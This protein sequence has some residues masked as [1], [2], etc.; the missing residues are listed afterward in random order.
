MRGQLFIFLVNFNLVSKFCVIPNYF[1]LPY[2]FYQGCC[3]LQHSKLR[4]TQYPINSSFLFHSFNCAGTSVHVFVELY[5]GLNQRTVEKKKKNIFTWINS[6]TCFISLLPF[7]KYCASTTK[8]TTC[9]NILNTM[10]CSVY[11]SLLWCRSSG[12]LVFFRII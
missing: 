11:L 12:R 4:C 8:R 3:H 7:P 1:V 10:K 2:V 5:C 9:E 6:L